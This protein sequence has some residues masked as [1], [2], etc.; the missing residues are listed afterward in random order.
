MPDLE[1]RT[2]WTDRPL[3]D[4]GS[5]AVPDDVPEADAFEQHQTLDDEEPETALTGEPPLEADPADVDEQNRSVPMDD[6]ERDS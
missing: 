6:D 1:I 2:Q 5:P 4:S 3:A